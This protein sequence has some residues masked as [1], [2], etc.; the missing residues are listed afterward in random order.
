M[1]CSIA[2]CE[3]KVFAKTKQLCAMHYYRLRR[4]GSVLTE[5]L[6]KKIA[7]KN[8]TDRYWSYV[9]KTEDCWAWTSA[10]D[11]YGYGVF[12]LAHPKRQTVK[13]HRISYELLVGPIPES[14][15]IDHL[16]FN[17]KCVNPSHLEVV[18]ASENGRRAAVNQCKTK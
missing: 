13:A 6:P 17:K 15:T 10:I 2:E 5:D 8:W 7:A 14:M 12:Q 4:H 9:D 18:T 3:K 1:A 11:S 16:C